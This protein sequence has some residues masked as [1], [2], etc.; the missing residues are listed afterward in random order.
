[1]LAALNAWAMA[2]EISPRR[3]AKILSFITAL[4]AVLDAILYRAELLA[5]LPGWLYVAAFFTAGAWLSYGLS[6]LLVHLLA[7]CLWPPPRAAR[8]RRIT[9]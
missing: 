9:W 3:L 6:A 5:W 2:Q 1:M 7:N 8:R 4:L